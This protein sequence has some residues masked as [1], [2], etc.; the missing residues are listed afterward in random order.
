MISAAQPVPVAPAILTVRTGRVTVFYKLHATEAQACG[1]YGTPLPGP[2]VVRYH[3]GKCSAVGKT[4]V[5]GF[6]M[7]MRSGVTCHGRVQIRAYSKGFE[8]RYVGPPEHPA[9]VVCKVEPL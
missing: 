1:D 4:V 8:G 5:C 7:R 6:R 2:C 9:A 3:V